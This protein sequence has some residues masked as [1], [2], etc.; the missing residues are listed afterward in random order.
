MGKVT[1]EFD[2][3]HDPEVINAYKII[4]EYANW[5]FN[6][7]K[8]GGVRNVE[9]LKTKVKELRVAIDGVRQ[10]AVA[11][12]KTQLNQVAPRNVQLCIDHLEDA[13]MR[14]GKVLEDLGS[15]L[16]KEFADKAE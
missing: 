9:E 15:E 12:Q 16:P 10:Q 3:M 2:P 7:N 1:I 8:K 13:K 6:K 5:V 11:L 14:L 4:S